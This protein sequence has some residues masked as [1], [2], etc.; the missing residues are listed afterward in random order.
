M[1]RP[2]SHKKIDGIIVLFLVILIIKMITAGL[3]HPNPRKSDEEANGYVQIEGNV[4]YSG[5]YG[6]NGKAELKTLIGK[7]GGLQPTPQI[8]IP[9]MTP[10][11]FSGDR[12]VAHF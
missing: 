10:R 7:A 3:P 2:R 1:E 6:I 5:V 11:I 8:P 4:K 9:E 12:I